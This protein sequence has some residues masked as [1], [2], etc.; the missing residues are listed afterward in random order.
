MST[1]ISTL[2]TGSDPAQW[3]P[4]ERA[5]VE[6]AGLVH[7]DSQSGTK[8]LADRPVVAAFLAHCARTGLDP[9]ARQIY[10]IARKSRGQ[11]KWQTQISIDGARLVAERSGE[12]EG[13]TTPEFTGDGK[14][15][16]DVW[17]EP[18]FPKAARVGVYRRGFRE[19]LYAVALWDAY[20]QTKYGGE[21]SDMWSKMGPLML[22]KC[23]EML[24]LRKAFPQDLSGLYSAEEMAQAAPAVAAPTS[25]P[26]PPP[27]APAE[28][29]EDATVVDEVTR[30]SG[31]VMPLRTYLEVIVPEVAACE[32]LDALRPLYV[33]AQSAGVLGQMV[34][35]RVTVGGLV[36]GRRFVIEG[37]SDEVPAEVLALVTVASAD[38][39]VDAE[40]VDEGTPAVLDGMDQR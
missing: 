22:A 36:Q 28:Q 24:A 1:A 39:P 32:A 37:R 4:E 10:C 34:A 35:P 3:D 11:L 23:A 9:I 18:G 7:T 2:P 40:V 16:T 27:A 31:E 21:V 19:P 14:S 38:E 17:L 29:V 13:Q 15:W 25:A 12:Y 30:A 33:E 5:M 26:T 6:A 8:T 20:V